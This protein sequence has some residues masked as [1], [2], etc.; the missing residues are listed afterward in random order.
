VEPLTDEQAWARVLGGDASEFGVIWDRHRDRVFRHLLGRG[1]AAGDA[2]DLAAVAFLELWRRRASVRFVDGSLLP[3]L[4][5]TAGNV[6]RNARR[7]RVRYQAFLARLPVPAASADAIGAAVGS[8]ALGPALQ[9][10]LGGLRP[11][12]RH[13]LLLTAVEGFT[14]AEAGEVLGLSEAAAKMRL[15]RVRRRLRSSL[16][17]LVGVEGELT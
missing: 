12:D 5:V 13:L 7:G 6:A 3:W 17:P 1:C 16:A 10:Q 9:A 8:D 4:L 2:E 11:V 15:S 14:I